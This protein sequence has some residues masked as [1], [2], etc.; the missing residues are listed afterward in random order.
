MKYPNVFNSMLQLKSK[1]ESLKAI[2]EDLKNKTIEELTVVQIKSTVPSFDEKVLICLENIV[3]FTDI[4]NE[5][6]DNNSICKLNYCDV[7]MF[8]EELN[9]YIHSKRQS[10]RLTKNFYLGLCEKYPQGFND[11][12][13]IAR[14]KKLF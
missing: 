4:I 5:V 3:E 6:H 9:S 7:R 8:S 2:V 11:C 1:K 13:L 10:P 14:N 12:F